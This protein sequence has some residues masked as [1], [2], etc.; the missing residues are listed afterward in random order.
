MVLSE[1]AKLI[2][3]DKTDVPSAQQAATICPGH[4]GAQGYI[5]PL[6]ISMWTFAPQLL[7]QWV[8]DQR[9]HYLGVSRAT[10]LFGRLCAH[11][12]LG[13]HSNKNDEHNDLNLQLTSFDARL[14]EGV[15]GCR[16][17]GVGVVY[18]EGHDAAYDEGCRT[19]RDYDDGIRAIKL[20]GG[21]VYSINRKL[22][23]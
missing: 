8:S 4:D 12:R 3:P 5:R 13:D 11:H 2:I 14:E 10:W 16:R 15:R 6:M 1:E 20:G 17:R 23:T 22:G 21:M 18:D 9:N 19:T 7:N